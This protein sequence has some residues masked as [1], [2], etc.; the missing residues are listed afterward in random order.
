MPVSSPLWSI[1]IGA[2]F[3]IVVVKQLFGG[4]G[5]NIVNPVLAAKVFLFTAWPSE[6]SGFTVPRSELDPFAIS[7]SNEKLDAITTATPLASLKNGEF[8]DTSLLDL[9]FGNTAG[10]I[11]EVSALLILIG[12]IY[13]LCRKVI[14][15]HIPLSFVATVAIITYIFPLNVFPAKFMAYELL[16]GV[17]LLGAIFM[18]TDY[19][20][21]P[22]T[23]KGKVIFGIG[24]GLITT[25]I[26]YFGG[27]AEGVSF[28]IL[29]MNLLVW[30]IDRYTKPIPFG[31][32]KK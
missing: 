12:G 7:I 20:T 5:K 27:Y 18:A 3:A 13:L 9:F 1:V 22:A 31:G 2:F 4:L 25:F 10:C 30:Y 15:Y 14:S 8:P 16:S 29:I 24:C 6:T 11:G 19:V 32:Q 28:A 17:L 21:S 26:R 23:K